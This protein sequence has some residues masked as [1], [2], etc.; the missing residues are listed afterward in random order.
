MTV[1]ELR[2]VL[3]KYDG[4]IEVLMVHDAWCCVSSIEEDMIELRNVD[5]DKVLV[6]DEDAPDDDEEDDEWEWSNCRK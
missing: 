3:S 6:F 1:K 2:E 5:G 4:D